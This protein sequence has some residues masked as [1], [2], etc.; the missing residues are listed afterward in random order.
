[1]LQTIVSTKDEKTWS[2]RCKRPRTSS[3]PK[4]LSKFKNQRVQSEDH[5]LQLLKN[6]NI[7]TD[8]GNQCCQHSSQFRPGDPNPDLLTPDQA[9]R[10]L[11][12]DEIKIKNPLETLDYYRKLEHL[13]ATQVS[14]MLF[15]LRSEL[16]AFL[17]KMTV[18]NPH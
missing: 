8:P 2:R 17:K 3:L 1:M 6:L 11:R 18:V 9:V 5:L 13:K 4:Q 16:D 15:Y 14:K 12:L 10:D 7:R